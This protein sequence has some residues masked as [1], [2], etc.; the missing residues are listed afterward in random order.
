MKDYPGYRATQVSQSYPDRITPLRVDR[1]LMLQPEYWG[2]LPPLNPINLNIK[3]A[4]IAALR[5]KYQRN[6]MWLTT[7]VSECP[8]M[9]ISPPQPM[10]DPTPLP[11]LPPVSSQPIKKQ[12]D[13]PSPLVRIPEIGRVKPRP[14]QEKSIGQLLGIC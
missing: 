5:L 7:S 11:T 8:P 3:S 12:H 1:P 14:F 2:E 9:P 4:E 13:R 6:A 10:L